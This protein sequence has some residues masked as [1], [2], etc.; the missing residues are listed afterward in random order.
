MIRPGNEANGRWQALPKHL[1]VRGYTHDHTHTH[2]HTRTCTHTHTHV[3][4]HTH[5]RTHAHMHTHT[6]ARTHTHAHLILNHPSSITIDSDNIVYVTEASNDPE[7]PYSPCKVNSCGLVD[8]I[9]YQH[10]HQKAY[11]P[12]LGDNFHLAVCHT[13][14]VAFGWLS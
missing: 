13:F 1:I 4:T 10:P 8:T 9:T 3:H 12:P 14:L 7:S 5:T 2:M 11:C 6:H